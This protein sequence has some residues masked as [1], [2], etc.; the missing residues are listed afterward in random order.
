MLGVCCSGQN[1][2]NKSTG[3]IGFVPQTVPAS[4]LV[5]LYFSSCFCFLNSFLSIDCISA[6]FSN[7]NNECFQITVAKAFRK[8]EDKACQQG[9]LSRLL[10]PPPLAFADGIDML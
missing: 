10:H 5:K 6:P 2:G 3:Q 4:G 9:E 7:C 8:A 1:L